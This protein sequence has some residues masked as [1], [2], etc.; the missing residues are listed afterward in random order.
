MVMKTHGVR[1]HQLN[2]HPMNAHFKYVVNGGAST[3]PPRTALC[4]SWHWGNATVKGEGQDCLLS[5]LRTGCT[6][7]TVRHRC[8]YAVYHV[9]CAQW[10]S[11]RALCKS[12]GGLELLRSSTWGTHLSC[13][14]PKGLVVHIIIFLHSSGQVELK[15]IP[16]AQ[17]FPGLTKLLRLLKKASLYLEPNQDVSK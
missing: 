13:G 3:L 5:A 6:V 12:S 9:H 16:S 14:D 15:T 8:A 10:G 7:W 1:P 2:R 11:V 17:T 4:D